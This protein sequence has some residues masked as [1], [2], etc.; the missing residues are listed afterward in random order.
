M[1][2]N[3]PT[4]T[5]LPPDTRQW[6][7]W[8][9]AEFPAYVRAPFAPRHR[10]MWAWLDGLKPSIRP[11]PLIELWPRGGAKS[12][13]AELGCA[14]VGRQLKRRFGLYV[15]GTQD[16]ADKHIQAVAALFEALGIERAV[17]EYGASKGWTRQMLRT[18]HGFNMLSIGLDKGVRGIKLD[19]LRPDFIIL[20]DVDN[21]HDTPATVEKKIQLITEN[22]LPAGS[23]DVA[24]L[25]VQNLIHNQSIAQKLADGTAEFL[26]DRLPVTIEPAVD[27]LEYEL[28][29]REDGTPY[30]VITA[31]RATWDGQDLET[32]ARQINAWGL[33]AFLREA[34]HLVEDPDGG[35][36]SHL[37][38]RRIA[39][40]ALPPLSRVC[41]WCDPAVTNTDDS[42]RHGIQCDGMAEDHTIYRLYSWEDRTSPLDVLCRAFVIALEYGAE[43]VGVETDQGGDTWHSVYNE[44][45]NTLT[46]PE[47]QLPEEVKR[48]ARVQEQRAK[49][50]ALR[51]RGKPVY[52]PP[53]RHAKAGST[54]AS[55]AARG[56]MMLADYE[57][58]RFVHVLGTHTVLERALRR[59]PKAKPYD[60]HD[61]AF[62]SWHYLTGGGM[63]NSAVGA[64]L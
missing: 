29:Q 51:M 19:E 23:P 30:Y 14:W 37:E 60:L 12:S 28:R 26:L 55:K 46:M 6:E 63:G 35:M 61:A 59:F 16:Q 21:R 44:A 64:F 11:R 38:Y 25:F 22:I 52:K 62:W 58:A 32:C 33:T 7:A 56:A 20:D 57:R 42:D 49:L 2:D 40:E 3:R 47:E 17:N 8:L 43:V 18:A 53:F 50:A 24:I 48:D 41:V 36:Y 54:G 5:T 9:Y 4:K 27:G 31:G 15:S 45:W 13:T 1:P 39:R 10:E 34:Q